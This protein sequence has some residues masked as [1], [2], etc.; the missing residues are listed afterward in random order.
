MKNM[1]SVYPPGTELLEWHKDKIENTLY[2]K[3]LKSESK[4][5]FLILIYEAICFSDSCGNVSSGSVRSSYIDGSWYNVFTEA[6]GTFEAN[7]PQQRS[8]SSSGGGGCFISSLL[9]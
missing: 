5:Y 9:N 8:N 3:I 4:T 2:Y 7:K 6:K 1:N